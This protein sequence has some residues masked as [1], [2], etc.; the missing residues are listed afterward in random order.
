MLTLNLANSNWHWRTSSFAISLE[1]KPWSSKRGSLQAS[2]SQKYCRKVSELTDCTW[3]W[4]FSRISL[5]IR[6]K[7]CAVPPHWLSFTNSWGAGRCWNNVFSNELCVTDIYG[8]I[9]MDALISG[10]RDVALFGIFELA[11]IS[12]HNGVSPWCANGAHNV[13]K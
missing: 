12:W 7:S 9:S 3:Y 10:H 2:S 8:V 13:G 5:S 11:N 1:M 6:S 4:I